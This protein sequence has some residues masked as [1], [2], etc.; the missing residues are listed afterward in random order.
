MSSQIRDEGHDEDTAEVEAEIADLEARLKAA[1]ERLSRSSPSNPPS[2]SNNNDN[3]LTRPPSSPTSSQHFLLLLSDS[4]LPLGSF[5]FSSGLDPGRLSRPTSSPYPFPPTPPPPSPFVL[6]AYRDPAAVADLDDQLD[7]AII[8]TVGRRASIAQGRALL[9]IWERSFVSS[10]SSSASSAGAAPVAAPEELFHFF[11]GDSNDR[12]RPSNPAPRLRAP[13]PLI[14]R[15][16]RPAGLTLP[17]TAYVFLLSHAKAVI[18][19]AVRSGLFGTYQAQRML[20]SPET[21]ALI[22]AMVAREWDTA[23]EDAGRASLPWTCGS[24]GTSCCI[25]VFLTAS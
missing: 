13:R 20:A 7:A 12:N 18:S 10:S 16:V 25:R 1:K 6:A 5:A 15:R 21:Q 17:Q 22:T 3:N 19:A 14:R 9:G 11:C 24:G 8:C 23:P 2:A 4:A